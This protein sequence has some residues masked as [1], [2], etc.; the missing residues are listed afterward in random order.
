MLIPRINL[1][2]FLLA[3]I[4]LPAKADGSLTF[5]A[6]LTGAEEVP[7]VST[8]ARGLASCRLSENRDTMIVNM[9]VTGLSGPVTGAAI[10]ESRRGTTGGA[11]KSL[12]LYQAG[13]KFYGVLTGTDLP[14]AMIAK[15]LNGETYINIFTE[16]NPN[17][18]IRGQLELEKELSMQAVLNGNNVVPEVTTNA[19][20]IASVKLS[21][22]NSRL[23]IKAQFGDLTNIT[24]VFLAMARPGNNG[25]NVLDLTTFLSGNRINAVLNTADLPLLETDS[26]TADNIYMYVTTS[27]HAGGEIRGQLIR[28]YGIDLEADLSGAQQ[29]PAVNTSNHGLGIFSLNNTFDT[30]MYDVIFSDL[31]SKVTSVA[32]FIG[33]RGLNGTT[34]IDITDSIAGNRITGKAFGVNITKAMVNALIRGDI[35]ISIKTSNNPNGEI[36]G[37]LVPSTRKTYTFELCGAQLVPA[38]NTIAQGLGVISVS[39][40]SSNIQYK[41]VADSLGSAITEAHLHKGARWQSGTEVLPLDFQYNAVNGFVWENAAKN[42]AVD[43]ASGSV[44]ADIHTAS[45]SG[46]EIRGQVA[47]RALCTEI[48]GL[49][50]KATVF[51]QVKIY[52]VPFADELTIEIDAIHAGNYTLE[53]C[54]MLGKSLIRQTTYIQS[55]KNTLLLNVNERGPGFYIVK[56]TNLKGDIFTQKI[57][58]Y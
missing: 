21:P 58:G 24:G 33:K 27:Q 43:I 57:L 51:A 16:A 3:F 30:L 13:N 38:V 52:P 14:P 18:E 32:L 36:R 37:Q 47:D 8:N 42:M 9:L 55:G 10:L 29:V 23:Q 35:Y 34:V 48:V 17:G 56:F 22:D 40:D 50:E 2:L 1:L 11:L 25:S 39:V 28:N 4:Y 53:I 12:E 20:G 44:Y 6:W 5:T 31:S 15:M 7:A 46:G 54:D 19:Y 26:L 49:P 41:I 45:N